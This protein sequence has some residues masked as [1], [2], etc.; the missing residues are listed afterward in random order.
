MQN[1]HRHTQKTRIEI[2]FADFD[3]PLFMKQSENILHGEAIFD[4]TTQV[5][6]VFIDVFIQCYWFE[7]HTHFARIKT[8]KSLHVLL[9]KNILAFFVAFLLSSA[10][11]TIQMFNMKFMEIKRLFIL[12]QLTSLLNDFLR[13]TYIVQY[14][15]TKNCTKRNA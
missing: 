11:Y 4:K 6:V 10:K 1:Q 12:S 9:S 3:Q 15:K 2:D 7:I 13:D 8:Y 5:D 14:P